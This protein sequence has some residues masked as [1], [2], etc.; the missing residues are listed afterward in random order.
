MRYHRAGPTV[1]TLST[2]GNYALEKWV[3][4]LVGLIYYKPQNINE[5]SVCG[6]GPAV[7]TFEGTLST[8]GNCGR[9]YVTRATHDSDPRK[10]RSLRARGRPEKPCFSRFHTEH[11]RAYATLEVRM[12]TQAH[13]YYSEDLLESS[14]SARSGAEGDLLNM[15]REAPPGEGLEALRVAAE[16]AALRGIPR[17]S[18]S[19]LADCY[20]LRGST[21]EDQSARRRKAVSQ[22]GACYKNVAGQVVGENAA[23]AAAAIVERHSAAAPLR[24]AARANGLNTW[25]LLGAILAELGVP[26]NPKTRLERAQDALLAALE[27]NE[28]RM[29]LEH[30]RVALGALD[31]MLR[32]AV[33]ALGLSRLV[34]IQSAV[35]GVGR[36]VPHIFRTGKPSG[37]RGESQDG[38]VGQ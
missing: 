18:A 11:S 16:T 17:L 31:G 28:G 8:R 26:V 23:R 21:P 7:A 37:Q 32:P 29:S 3:C 14:P 12:T 10:Q 30:C 25:D 19:P 27:D 2:R 20:A 33:S 38:E 34:I 13:E 24:G 1:S 36:V 6:F 4:Q 22:T 5:K 35:D 9:C 15:V